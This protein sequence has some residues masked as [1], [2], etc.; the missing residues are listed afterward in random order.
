MLSNIYD[1]AFCKNNSSV[2]SLIF[3]KIFIIVVWQDSQCTVYYSVYEGASS[4]KTTKVENG[5]IIKELGQKNFPP[6]C[7]TISFSPFIKEAE[8]LLFFGLK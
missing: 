1:G 5:H 2:E 8:S 7:L 6:V 3:T 4:N